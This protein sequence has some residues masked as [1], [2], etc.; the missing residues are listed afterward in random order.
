MDTERL[1]SSNNRYVCFKD[2]LPLYNPDY[3]DIKYHAYHDIKYHGY[4]SGRHKS[5]GPCHSIKPS[6]YR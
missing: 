2:L 5:R 3:R 6:S 4:Y 1:K